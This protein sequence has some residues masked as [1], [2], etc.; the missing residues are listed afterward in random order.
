MRCHVD[1][2]AS[3][4]GTLPLAV[5][6]CPVDAEAGTAERAAAALVGRNLLHFKNPNG[7]EPDAPPD[8]DSSPDLKGSFA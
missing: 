5:T 8:M 6:A 7:T 2:S 3:A 4:W 1:P